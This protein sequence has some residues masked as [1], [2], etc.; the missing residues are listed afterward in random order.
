[1]TF[2]FCSCEGLLG[3]I[4]KVLRGGVEGSEAA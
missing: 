4:C 1:M 2:W 3:E